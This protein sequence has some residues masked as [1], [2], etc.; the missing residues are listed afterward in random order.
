MSVGRPRVAILADFPW[1]FFTDGATGR[2]GGQ[3]STWLSQLAVEFARSAHVDVH[4]ITL[5]SRLRWGRV[6]RH[7]WGHQTFL[8]LGSSPLTVD[9]ALG[10]RVSTYLLRR[11]LDDIRPHLIHCWGT[12]RTYA[13]IGA[14][15]ETPSI[16]SMQGVIT[17]LDRLRCLP[18]TWVWRRLTALE[19]GRLRSASVITCE[20]QWAA[21]RV[22][23]VAPDADVRQIE[24][25][26]DDS[27]YQLAW[28]PDTSAP[29]AVFI[30]T[31]TRCKGI[32]LLLDALRTLP[33]RPWRCLFLG[34]GP[35]VDAVRHARLP[36]VECLGLVRWDRLQDVLRR[37]TCLVHP[38]LAD[39]SPNAVKEA[40]VVGVPVIT[41]AHGGQAGYI[42]HDQ[43]GLIVDPH[44]AVTLGAALD[45][46]MTTPALAARLGAAR[47]AEDRAY[48]RASETARRFLDLYDA[49]L[50]R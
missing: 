38:T 13:S 11:A 34:D 20:S 26:V 19:P 30:G 50:Q 17:H 39:S 9:L 43:N 16:L 42:H 12:E 47:H 14:T 6:E 49:L 46:V 3:L 22:R 35:L 28:T 33:Q 4:W 18:D 44:D 45:A 10:C 27:F 1:S 29:Y 5:D 25:G 40:R 23:A 41:T 15:A 2:G 7:T 31:L 21:E 36:G 48:F 32:P 24:Y 8:R 37:A